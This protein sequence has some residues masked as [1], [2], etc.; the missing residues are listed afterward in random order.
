MNE[1]PAQ[2]RA[3]VNGCVFYTLWQSNSDWSEMSSGHN[4]TV[5]QWS[6]C[7]GEVCSKGLGDSQSL[8]LLSG[9]GDNSDVTVEWLPRT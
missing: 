9:H 5:S 1:F 6:V 7:G 3:L 4:V 2:C 8:F